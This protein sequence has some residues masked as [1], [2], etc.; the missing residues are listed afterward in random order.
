[1]R[2]YNLDIA[3]YNIRFESE[4]D[5]P[6]LVPSERFDN[7]IC[8][9]GKPDFLIRVHTGSFTFHEK[10]ERVFNAPYVEEVNGL[11]MKKNDE[12][13]SIFQYN[14]DLFL[15][16]VFPYSGNNEE[17]ILKFSLSQSVWDLWFS[18]KS[19]GIDPLSYPLDGLIL[20]YLTVIS[21]DIMIHASG[22]NYSGKGYLFSGVSG[23]GKS[24]MAKLWDAFGAEV[25]HDDRLILRSESDGF[26]M[27]NTPVYKNEKPAKSKLDKIFLIEHGKENRIVPAGGAQCVS[28]IMA[29]CIQHNWDKKIITRLLDSVSGLCDKI[30]ASRLFFKP[31]HSIIDFI[32]GNEKR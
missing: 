22:V 10:T 29:N 24:T 17:A 27:F 25:I 18:S 32:C 11:M 12:F 23:K 13:W 9:G 16:T 5:G 1:M 19:K 2:N 21:G 6:E 15:K 7:F 26:Y 31:D 14:N 3:G 8:S 20:Y 4:D 30:P 28:L